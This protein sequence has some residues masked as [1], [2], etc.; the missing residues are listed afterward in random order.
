MGNGTKPRDWMGELVPVRH[1][2]ELVP[3]RHMNFVGERDPLFFM[4]LDEIRQ[5]PLLFSDN[6]FCVENEGLIVGYAN[7]IEHWDEATFSE[8]V[9]KVQSGNTG[10][11]DF[12]YS[13]HIGTLFVCRHQ[14][15]FSVFRNGYWYGSFQTPLTREILERWSYLLNHPPYVKIQEID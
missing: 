10:F 8:F 2:D 4:S 1:R 14:V 6:L 13:P 7:Q 3:L 11:F 15:Y 5:L 9:R 12:S